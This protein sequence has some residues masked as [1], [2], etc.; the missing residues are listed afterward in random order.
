MTE[1]TTATPPP[2][3]AGAVSQG[4]A[5]PVNLSRLVPANIRAV[6]PT[7][8]GHFTPWLLENADVLS[9]TSTAQQITTTSAR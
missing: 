4:I 2:L 7:E 1:E 6:W 8:G 9:R 3:T 5:P